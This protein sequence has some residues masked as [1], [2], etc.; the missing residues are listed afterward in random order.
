[1]ESYTREHGGRLRKY[2]R[3]TPKGRLGIEDFLLEWA[4]LSKVYEFIKEEL[5]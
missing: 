4:E 2:Y 1:V 3:I 5:T